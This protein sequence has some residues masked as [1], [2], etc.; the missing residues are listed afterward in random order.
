MFLEPLE[1]KWAKWT[2]CS[3]SCGTDGVRTRVK[4][5]TANS[6]LKSKTKCQIILQES[7]EEPCNN[8]PCPGKSEHMSN[9]IGSNVGLVENR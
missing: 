9:K 3:K 4:T 2:P 6:W 7:E 8:K 5:C 1:Y